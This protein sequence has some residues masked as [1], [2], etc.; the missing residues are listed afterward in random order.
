MVSPGQVLVAQQHGTTGESPLLAGTIAT[1]APESFTDELWVLLPEFSDERPF[2]PCQWGAIHGAGLPAA[3]AKCVLAFDDEETPVV[4]WWAPTEGSSIVS[5]LPASPYDGQIVYY[6]TTAMAEGGVVWT[7]RY[8]AASSSAHK[9]EFVG[10]ASWMAGPAG[11]MEWGV[12]ETIKLGG[13]PVLT[14][15]VAGVYYVGGDLRNA[16]LLSKSGLI[17]IDAWVAVN[18][19]IGNAWLGKCIFNT[20]WEGSP[21]TGRVQ[22]ELKAADK[23]EVYVKK[24][25]SSLAAFASFATIEMRPVRLG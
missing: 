1:P 4:I 23:L 15:P 17:E 18:G 5:T 8:R 25:A 11:E 14:A 10:G 24:S 19:V 16:Q 7:L 2:G 22:L 13:S 12:E 20:A 21:L 9:W 6:Q 3:G